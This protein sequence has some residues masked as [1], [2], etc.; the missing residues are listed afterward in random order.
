MSDENTRVW[1]SPVL[2]L[3]AFRNSFNLMTPAR[4]DMLV[5]VEEPAVSI[6]GPFIGA[7]PP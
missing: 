4:R 2:F 5:A 1:S 7:V 3:A 6:P